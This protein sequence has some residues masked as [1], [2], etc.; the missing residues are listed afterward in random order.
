MPYL[1]RSA[2]NVS[3]VLLYGK[4]LG[5]VGTLKKSLIDFPNSLISSKILHT[6]PCNSENNVIRDLKYKYLKDKVL[7]YLNL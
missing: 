3:C 2:P 4:Q 5:Q 7:K 1:S 6:F